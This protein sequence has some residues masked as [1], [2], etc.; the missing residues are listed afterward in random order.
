MGAQ[1]PGHARALLPD[2]DARR[3]DQRLPGAGEADH[4]H[5]RADLCDH[6]TGLEGHAA[7]RRQGIQIADQHRLAARPHLL[8]RHTGGL[9]SRAQGPGSVQ[10][11]SAERLRQALYAAS[12]QG[13][14]LGGH[15]DAGSRPGQS[16]GCGV[17]FHAALRADEDQPAIRG[18]CGPTRQI[19]PPRHRPGTILRREQAEGGFYEAGARRRVRPDHASVQDQQSDQEGE[20]LGLHHENRHLRHGLSDARARDRH[21]ARCESP[22]GRALSG[23]EDGYRGSQIQRSKQVRHALPQGAPAAGRS[24]LVGDHVQSRDVLREQPAQPVLDQ[25]STEPEEK[26]GRFDRSL[27]SA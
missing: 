4:G 8:Q 7:R 21:R 20:R 6:R 2:A 5:R 17:V 19:C 11:G 16:Y 12:G 15:Q 1:H 3:L 25:S 23:F 26:S 27:H 22:A 14:S 13:R 24:I 10:T 9:R 18:G